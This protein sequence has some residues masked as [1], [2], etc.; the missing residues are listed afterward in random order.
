MERRETNIDPG[1]VGGSGESLPADAITLLHK[2]SPEG[3]IS[4][5]AAIT[6][7][8]ERSRLHRTVAVSGLQPLAHPNNAEVG[9]A[10]ERQA[11]SL[12]PTGR[13]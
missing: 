10:P 4:A 7:N 2:L 13:R 9:G 11:H 8:G 6:A 12:S 1:R 5:D 3:A